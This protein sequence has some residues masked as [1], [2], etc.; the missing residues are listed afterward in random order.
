MPAPSQ[1][2]T[3][4]C[5][6]TTLATPSNVASFPKKITADALGKADNFSG[7]FEDEPANSI[8]SEQNAMN[9]VTSDYLDYYYEE[10]IK[11]DETGQS[12]HGNGGGSRGQ[13]QQQSTPGLNRVAK[14]KLV[15]TPRRQ[16]P[17]FMLEL[18]DRFSKGGVAM[19]TSPA[20][21]WTPEAEDYSQE[22]H[23]S[24][25]LALGADIVRSFPNINKEGKKINKTQTKNSIKRWL[26]N[27]F[28][29]SLLFLCQSL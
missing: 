1:T 26:N 9:R 6:N 7:G 17:E 19:L 24:P 18:Y 11:A 10:F 16:P 2:T 15:K 20:P 14:L 25:E 12:S 5:S 8:K 23:D 22:V 3:P 4:I 29:F 27:F 21:T 13:H 28:F